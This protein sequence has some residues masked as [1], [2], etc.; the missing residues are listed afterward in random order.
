MV[1]IHNSRQYTWLLNHRPVERTYARPSEL[2]FVAPALKRNR[3]DLFERKWQYDNKNCG[4]RPWL[5]AKSPNAKFCE[6]FVS[7]RKTIRHGVNIALVKQGLASV[8]FLSTISIEN[9]TKRNTLFQLRPQGAFPRGG[10]WRKSALGKRL[11]L[12]K[13]WALCILAPTAFS[14]KREKPLRTRGI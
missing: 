13:D 3:Q 5:K 12:F 8:F 9:N 6:F 11:T 7:A 2:A 14:V 10:R 4:V 1:Q